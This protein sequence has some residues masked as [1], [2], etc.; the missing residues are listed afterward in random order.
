M[1]QVALIEDRLTKQPFA[2]IVLSQD[3]PLAFGAAGQGEVWAHWANAEKMSIEQ[4]RDSLDITLLLNDPQ[5]ISESNIDSIEDIFSETTLA[6]LKN[7]L[8]QKALLRIIQTKSLA[9]EPESNHSEFDIE[10]DNSIEETIFDWPLTDVGLASIDVAYKQIAVDYKTKAFRNDVANSS[11]AIKVKGVR[12]VWDADMP[13]GGGWR[14]PD[15]TPFGGQF[16]NRL[17]IG[18]TYGVMRRIGEKLQGSI[19]D[20]QKLNNNPNTTET[21]TIF[22]VGRAIE[23]SA[24]NRRVQRVAKFERRM[25]RRVD[26]AAERTAKEKLR[27][28]TPTFMDSY[29]ALNPST[30]RRDRARIAAGIVLQRMGQDITQA[31][32]NS[33]TSRRAKRR[34][35]AAITPDKTRLDK[36][37][38]IRSAINFLDSNVPQLNREY[39]GRLPSSMSS[40][41]GLVLDSQKVGASIKHVI[42][43]DF[44]AMVPKDHSFI[45]VA[46][47]GVDLNN[48]DG[49]GTSYTDLPNWLTRT[50]FENIDALIESNLTGKTFTPLTMSDII[51]VFT[52]PYTTGGN[53]P[54]LKDRTEVDRITGVDSPYTLVQSA[55]RRVSQELRDNGGLFPGYIGQAGFLANPHTGEM[56]D[57]QRMLPTTYLGSTEMARLRQWFPEGIPNYITPMEYHGLRGETVAEALFDT[58]DS[59]RGWVHVNGD[60]PDKMAQDL[61]LQNTGDNDYWK[62]LSNTTEPSQGKQIR[63]R[64]ADK[65]RATA[66]DIAAPNR[67]LDRRSK[68]PIRKKST[69]S[70]SIFLTGSDWRN[71]KTI[72][73]DNGTSANWGKIDSP[74]QDFV[75]AKN[76]ISRI[77]SQL[78]IPYLS[79][80]AIKKLEDDFQNLRYEDKTPIDGV[81]PDW[82]T[83]FP[84]RAEKLESILGTRYLFKRRV[85]KESARRIGALVVRETISADW[86]DSRK[87]PG[88][89]FPAR[90]DYHLMLPKS[91]RTFHDLIA[92]Y[93]KWIAS[94]D[95]QKEF[96]L[97]PQMGDLG[98]YRTEGKISIFFDE[99]GNVLQ[100]KHFGLNPLAGTEGFSGQLSYASI[101]PAYETAERLSNPDSVFTSEIAGAMKA[102]TYTT[103]DGVDIFENMDDGN[104]KR[105][106]RGSK[107]QRKKITERLTE[108]IDNLFGPKTEQQRQVREAYGRRPRPTDGRRERAAKYMRRL[109]S[110]I[111]QEPI[112]PED[113]PSE[114]PMYGRFNELPLKNVRRDALIGTKTTVNDYIN[115]NTARELGSIPIKDPVLALKTNYTSSD[116]LNIFESTPFLDGIRNVQDTISARTEPGPNDPKGFTS[117]PFLPDSFDEKHQADLI[118]IID[119]W[120]REFHDPDGPEPTENRISNFGRLESDSSPNGAIVKYSKRKEHK[121]PV[122]IEAANGQRAHFMDDDGNH[123][124]SAVVVKNQDGTE[125]VKFIAS[126]RTRKL[127]EKGRIKPKR[128]TTEEPTFFQRALGKF[129]RQP[130]PGK[131]TQ[132][133]VRSRVRAVTNSSSRSGLRFGKTTTGPFLPDVDT[134]TDA[135]KDAV[136]TNMRWAF[137]KSLREL[138]GDLGKPDNDT[139]PF[140]EDEY[141]NYIDQLAS[142]GKSKYLV[143]ARQT[144]LHN[145]LVLAQFDE[146]QDFN[147]VNNL[148]PQMRETVLVRSGIIDSSTLGTYL[149]RHNFEPYVRQ[150]TTTPAPASRISPPVKRPVTQIPKSPGTGPDLTPGVGN[151][152]LGIAYD[153]KTG[154]YI[155]SNTGEYVE[156]L[157][158]LP[159]EEQT[160]YTAVDIPNAQRVEQRAS[161]FSANRIVLTATQFPNIP[162]DNNVVLGRP[163]EETAIAPGFLASDIGVTEK[164]KTPNA[165]KHLSGVFKSFTDAWR[166][167]MD[168]YNSRGGAERWKLGPRELNSGAD[169]LQYVD[170]TQLPRDPSTP[171]PMASDL[172]LK[173]MVELANAAAASDSMLEGI[174][175]AD[176]MLRGYPIAQIFNSLASR[177]A[178]YPNESL[179]GIDPTLPLGEFYALSPGADGDAA[180]PQMIASL[181]KALQL[182]HAANNPLPGWSQQARDARRAEANEAWLDAQRN[183][184]ATYEV[185]VASRDAALKDWRELNLNLQIPHP[186]GQAG[187]ETELRMAAHTRDRFILNGLIAERAQYLL[188]KHIVNNPAALRAIEDYKRTELQE[189][190]KLLNGKARARAARAA[191]GVNRAEGLYDNQPDILDPWNSPNPPSAPRP[192]SDIARIR[193]E[194]R[195]QT[196]FDVI[197]NN[198]AQPLDAR[199]K[200]MFDNI[201]HFWESYTQNPSSPLVGLDGTEMAGKTFQNAQEAHLATLW[202]YNGFSSL[203]VLANRDEI[204]AALKE[205]D[206]NGAPKY[207]LITRGVGGQAGATPAQ[208]IQ[209]VTDALT[210]DRFVPGR[211]G[212]AA[213]IGE[214][215]TQRPNQWSSWHGGSGG[216]MI[217]LVSRDM[218]IINREL[219]VEIFGSGYG[220]ETYESLWSIYNAIGAPESQGVNVGHGI[221]SRYGV[222]PRSILPDPNTGQFT[223]AQL[224]EL[225]DH[226]DRLTAVGAP[227]S[228]RT[229]V[230]ANWGIVTLEGMLRDGR[231]GGPLQSALFPGAARRKQMSQEELQEIEDTRELW[232]TWLRQRMNHMVDML[233]T[234]QDTNGGKDVAAAR[235][236]KQ[237]LINVRSLLYMRGENIANMMGYDALVADGANNKELTPSQL[238][239]A[240]LE[241]RVSRILVLNRSAMIMED[242]PVT[243]YTDYRPILESIAYP[244]GT[245]ALRER[246]MWN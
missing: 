16:T 168:L 132:Q 198:G 48:I 25:Q 77:L 78:R 103:S 237:V 91:H 242:S 143:G 215:W 189:K 133:S 204:I 140:S 186:D 193:D 112:N 22:N 58:N 152:A 159:I 157:S 246:W 224:Q 179:L 37:K 169:G 98:N 10:D 102:R 64:I 40:H 108:G 245:Y 111:R 42:V 218:K 221:Q 129:R 20:I 80:K 212:V 167:R 66:S 144:A 83:D 178:F 57:P 45:S 226:V 177:D 131:Q 161:Q 127:I 115:G 202:H 33:S 149:Q 7:Q 69:P 183:L 181:N 241:G 113:M 28:A 120:Q 93:D 138:K 107:P 99:D 192:I 136:A 52:K 12:A 164:P 41:G 72:L 92:D 216:T 84:E 209:M 124:A 47:S 101:D 137:E 162:K 185:H 11:L 147:Y 128:N 156:D 163:Q 210:G 184:S 196:M 109:A 31:G 175:Y 2:I 32:F 182:E 14:C 222:I 21:S 173:D 27:S 86:A 94:P 230:D 17:G 56:M 51:D 1:K 68:K 171:F 49:Q 142:S 50:E 62:A 236:N 194:H 139:S 141:L 223:P 53:L 190:A 219:F 43:A 195:A 201:S 217:A 65:L 154:L 71:L 240:F 13:G 211:G 208:Q 148:K 155:D 4:M 96:L 203:P 79:G 146:T 8:S 75:L 89:L 36:K 227:P 125:E 122:Y 24:E 225:Q 67:R 100:V 38:K 85:R 205:T 44:D 61:L 106:K 110:R 88:E 123:I 200:E 70:P 105:K 15:D 76:E 220:G 29:R 121:P 26:R 119:D 234:L 117:T 165:R 87:N 81:V 54:R 214:Y 30:G 35:P 116:I 150:Q 232:N 187:A 160:I 46:R 126:A 206:M 191:S 34:I 231:L 130:T 114:Q 90:I 243:H 228:T 39:G 95:A 233:R 188:D 63:A 59:S 97:A 74:T 174:K 9:D 3:K 158:N 244:D 207:V 239:K 166:R 176:S 229:T 6:D 55:D 151:A 235:H 104:K 145:L 82:D 135:Q 18:C 5:P 170:F 118:Q 19:R 199:Q 180:V 73:S 172:R 213:G 197:T 153:A 134:L 238:W 60:T 23:E